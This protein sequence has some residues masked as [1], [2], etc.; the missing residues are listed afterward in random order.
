[1]A[2][3]HGALLAGQ[4]AGALH[5]GRGHR[6]HA[7]VRQR[8]RGD[9][10]VT[11]RRLEAEAAGERSGERRRLTCRRAEAGIGR[12][13]EAEE[14]PQREAMSVLEPPLPLRPL[15]LD[16]SETGYVPPESA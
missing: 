16:T 14:L 10:D 12:V 5:R 1:M 8:R 13:Q 11:L 15:P 2:L 9:R 6:D 3:E 7:E 4:R